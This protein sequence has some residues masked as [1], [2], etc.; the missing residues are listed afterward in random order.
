[1]EGNNRKNSLAL[2]IRLEFN[3]ISKLKIKMSCIFF[4]VNFKGACRAA[5]QAT[6]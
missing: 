6:M 2:Y 1:M 5:E 4:L 3:E